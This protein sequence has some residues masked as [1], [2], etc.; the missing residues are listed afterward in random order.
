MDL[1][2]TD[3]NGFLLQKE[4]EGIETTA[5]P[6]DDPYPYFKIMVPSERHNA[7]VKALSIPSPSQDRSGK[8]T[9]ICPILHCYK[10]K[11]K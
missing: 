3:P 2:T 1:T 11:S 7:E 9:L 6:W 4:K 5:I 10:L 8:C